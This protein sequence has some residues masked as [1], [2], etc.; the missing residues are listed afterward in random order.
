[1]LWLSILGHIFHVKHFQR[2]AYVKKLFWALIN[3]FKRVF[4]RL[5]WK[6]LTGTN[7]LAYYEN[8]LNYRQKSFVTLGPGLRKGLSGTNTPAYHEHL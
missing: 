4:G 2:G 6:T 3:Q 8:L 7:T 5:G 1:M